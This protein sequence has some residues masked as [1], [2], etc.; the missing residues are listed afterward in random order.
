MRG[1]GSYTYLLILVGWCK[2]PSEQLLN[3]I[4]YNLLIMNRI[5]I[6]IYLSLLMRLESL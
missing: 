5:K 6:C 2:K 1:K 3:Q 4:T